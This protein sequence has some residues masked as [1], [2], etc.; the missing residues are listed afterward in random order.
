MKLLIQIQLSVIMHID[1]LIT[2]HI[3]IKRAHEKN[4]IMSQKWTI[5]PCIYPKGDGCFN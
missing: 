1:I 3:W 2:T 4:V 5:Q